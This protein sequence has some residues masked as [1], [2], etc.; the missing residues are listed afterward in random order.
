MKRA[1]LAVDPTT[2]TNSWTERVFSMVKH[3]QEHGLF[4]QLDLVSL[5]HRNLY[6][7]PTSEY[8]KLESKLLKEAR[9]SLQFHLKPQ[10]NFQKVRVIASDSTFQEDNVGI[11]SD[12]TRRLKAEVLIVGGSGRQGLAYWMLGS[13]SET[14]TLTATVPVLVLKQQ[15]DKTRFGKNPVIVLAVDIEYPPRQNVLKRVGEL[16]TRLKASTHFLYVLPKPRLIHKVLEKP[17]ERQNILSLS[18]KF[19][20]QLQSRQTKQRF[21]IQK[22]SKTIAHTINEYA[23]RQRAWAIVLTPSNR[24]RMHTILL[25]STARRTLALSR[26]PLLMLRDANR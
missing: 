21:V 24:G 8:R 5:I 13:F 3:F 7:L 18:Q 4:T 23:E 1:V 26:L 11:I 17:K 10:L 22:E 25:G 14:A 12:I 2:F 15:I 19:K 9:A 16:A 20:A 6:I